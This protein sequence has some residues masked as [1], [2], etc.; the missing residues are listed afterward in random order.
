MM[1]EA[2]RHR[3]GGAD[4]RPL[5][6][7]PETGECGVKQQRRL[8]PWKA[9]PPTPLVR[10]VKKAAPRQVGNMKKTTPTAGQG[11]CFFLPP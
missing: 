6:R 8:S 3:K 9:T 7:S 11:F 2:L 1:E 10:G 5:K 4:A